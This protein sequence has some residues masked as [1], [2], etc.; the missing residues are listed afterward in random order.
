MKK[1]VVRLSVLV[2]I[3]IFAFLIF[4]IGPGQIWAQIRK[5]SL[6]NFLILVV[7]RILYW[8][9]RTLCWKVILDAYEGNTSLFQLFTARMCGHAVSQLT[10]TAQVGSEATRI[11]MAGC[12]SKKISIASVIV[13]KT[14]EFLTVIFFIVVGLAALFTRIALP[15]KLKIVFIGGVALFSLV[16]LF[17]FSSKKKDCWAGAWISWPGSKYGLN[18][19]KNTGRK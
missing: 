3:L 2:G 19:W 17:I 12:S 8:A 14:I 10:P 13:D 18:S 6:Q 11:L 15:G 7:L 5:I 1:N 4:K 9:L 16:V